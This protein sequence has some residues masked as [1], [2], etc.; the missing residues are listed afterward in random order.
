MLRRL[1]TCQEKVLALLQNE[2]QDVLVIQGTAHNGNIFMVSGCLS[3]VIRTIPARDWH[4]SWLRCQGQGYVRV[5]RQYR[6]D[7][8]FLMDKRVAGRTGCW[9]GLLYMSS[10]HGPF[11]CRN[12]D[13]LCRICPAVWDASKLLYLFARAC[14]CVPG[15]P[16]D[17]GL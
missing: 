16:S 15:M 8:S 4:S 14:T 6:G 3:L 10:A 5:L 17:L 1:L 7:H 9:Q 13:L 12:A 11:V 2:A